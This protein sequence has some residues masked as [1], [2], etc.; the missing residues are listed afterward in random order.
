MST[1]VSK[2]RVVVLAAMMLV[3]LLAH[4]VAATD[5]DPQGDDEVMRPTGHGLR[6]T[7]Q[8]A[9]GFCRAMLTNGDLGRELNLTEEQEA[10]MSEALARRLMQMG[11]A[12]GQHLQPFLETFVESMVIHQAKFTP[13]SA[14]EFGKR[15][16]PVLPAIRQFV[17]G[18]A[19]DAR[20]ILTPDQYAGFEETARQGLQGVDRFEGK[21]KRWAS[22][23]A[24]DGED[25]DH[26]EPEDGPA[27]EAS[28]T[29]HEKPKTP[30]AQ[31]ARNMAEWDLRR[32]GPGG[33]LRF[34]AG[35]KYFF[36]LD[37][38]QS[39]E[40]DQILAEYQQRA[41]AVMTD[42]WKQRI[43]RNRT[44]FHL[45]RS[46]GEIAKAPWLYHL[47]REYEELF[48]PV[49]KIERAFRAAVLALVTDEQREAAFAGVRDRAAKHGLTGKG[50]ED[51]GAW[52]KELSR[53]RTDVG[54][55]DNGPTEE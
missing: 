38:A 31:H 53:R 23:G 44:K 5:E 40:A 42:E 2:P 7:P 9:R 46:L 17:K 45:R 52:L 32:V 25:L 55:G 22:G 13:D 33:W 3:P 34:L 26:Y 43:R 47:D 16:K 12:N 51:V 19:E 39:A 49:G 28:G 54:S 15:A 10:Q 37:D 35:V 27:P 36:K 20:P 29:D 11:H 18:L 30:K 21:M 48:A 8:I 24:N 6:L 14:R 50:L 1:V 4:R 41:E